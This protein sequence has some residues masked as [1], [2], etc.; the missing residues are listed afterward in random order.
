[1][2][3]VELEASVGVRNPAGQ[4]SFS[5][6][7]FQIEHSGR[8]LGRMTL[9]PLSL[10]ARSDTVYS[11]KGRIDLAND[12]SIIQALAY[13]RKPQMLNE[14]TVDV[15]AKVK[16]KGGARKNMEF[17]DIPVEKLLKIIQK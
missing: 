11:L 6:M 7:Y 5:D 8:I 4:V 16:L 3:A 13:L 10:M 17:N 12:L 15:T 1:M 2:K 14:A 9:A